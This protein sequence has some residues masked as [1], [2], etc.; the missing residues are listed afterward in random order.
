MVV[1]PSP[2]L[3]SLVTPLI[4][5]YTSGSFIYPFFY[6]K[7]CFCWFNQGIRCGRG[8][9]SAFPF[10]SSYCAASSV[11]GGRG[12]FVSVI[13]VG[14][15]YTINWSRFYFWTYEEPCVSLWVV[16]FK[17]FGHCTYE[18]FVDLILPALQVWHRYIIYGSVVTDNKHYDPVEYFYIKY[19]AYRFWERREFVIYNYLPSLACYLF[20]RYL[21]SFRGTG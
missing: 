20:Y 21:Y 6:G 2:A 1:A 10:V 12:R 4:L 13:A 19:S 7:V 11:F 15:P 14:G 17:G 5:S 3:V 18:S 9:Y 16:P 8:L